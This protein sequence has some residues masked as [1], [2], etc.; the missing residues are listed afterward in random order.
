MKRHPA[1]ADR[2]VQ[3]RMRTSFSRVDIVP[4]VVRLCAMNLYLYGG[5]TAESPTERADALDS[6][7]SV[8][9]LHPEIE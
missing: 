7:G 3:A 2:R 8:K 9:Q 1:A 6:L 5:A 4:D